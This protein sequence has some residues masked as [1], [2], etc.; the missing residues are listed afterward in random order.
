MVV[1]LRR[2]DQHAASA[3]SQ[4]LRGGIMREPGLPRGGPEVQPEYDFGALLDR[5]ARVFGDASMRPRIFDRGS[6]KGGDVVE[7]FLLLSGIAL[8]IPPEASKK[9][10]NPSIALEG[11]ALLL[12]AGRRLAAATGNDLWRDTP[13]WRRLAESVGEALTGRGWRPTQAEARAFMQRF[14]A[15]NERARSRFFP[16][17]P[18]LFSLDFEDLA[19]APNASSAGQPGAGRAGCAG[20]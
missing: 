20:A 8:P 7:D 19:V 9:N 10:S 1:Y 5:F 16:H 18:S 15:T 12:A 14:S 6:L 11:Q 3:Y 4:V 2:Q 13:Q 17:L